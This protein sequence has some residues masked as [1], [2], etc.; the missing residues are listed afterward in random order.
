MLLP[1]TEKCPMDFCKGVIFTTSIDNI[2]VTR[3]K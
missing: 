3:D 1:P 2:A